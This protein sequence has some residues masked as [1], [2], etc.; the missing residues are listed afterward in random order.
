MDRSEGISLLDNEVVEL[1]F[2]LSAQQAEALGAA[3]DARGLTVGEVIR[4]L[5]RNF[6]CQPIRRPSWCEPERG[7]FAQEW[8]D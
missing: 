6:C 1:S 2:L 4:A 3:A 8:S 7:L 5:I